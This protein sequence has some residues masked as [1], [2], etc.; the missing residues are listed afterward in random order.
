MNCSLTPAETFVKKPERDPYPK[1]HT[2]H[3]RVARKRR[4]HIETSR[5]K[6]ADQRAGNSAENRLLR[7]RSKKKANAEEKKRTV[8][9]A[10]HGSVSRDPCRP[11]EVSQRAHTCNDKRAE[12]RC[13]N[14]G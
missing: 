4:Q 12:N 2:E 6:K 13:F 1:P 5:G 3:D 7:D 11:D 14:A 8:R 10:V 9:E